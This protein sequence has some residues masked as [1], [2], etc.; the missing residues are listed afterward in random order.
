MKIFKY[1]DFSKSWW[2]LCQHQ[3]R[4]VVL[5]EIIDRL[6]MAQFLSHFVADQ[7][8][9]QWRHGLLNIGRGPTGFLEDLY[10]QIF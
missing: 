10:T 8:S 5:P 7:I 9:L 1:I 6:Q 4:T 3:V 2:V